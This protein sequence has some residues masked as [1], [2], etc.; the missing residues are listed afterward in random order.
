[1]RNNEATVMYNSYIQHRNDRVFNFW[2]IE[3]ILF[4]TFLNSVTTRRL[5]N[6]LSKSSLFNS[7][8]H[9]SSFKNHWRRH[10]EVNQQPTR[11][12]AL[13]VNLPVAHVVTKSQRIM[14]LE[15]SLSCLQYLTKFVCPNLD[16]PRSLS[17]VLLFARLFTIRCFTLAL[18]LP[19][20]LVPQNLLTD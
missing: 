4:N 16:K 19:R 9:A 14:E 8:W 7:K 5:N 3:L 2:P 13:S 10:W 17:N 1:M 20:F 15:T 11:S 12:R 18:R 6:N